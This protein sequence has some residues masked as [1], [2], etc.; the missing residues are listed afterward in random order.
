MSAPEHPKPDLSST[1]EAAAVAIVDRLQ[2][3][4]Y[5]AYFAGGCVRDRLLGIEPVDY[6]IA[7]DAPPDNVIEL[8]PRATAVGKSFGVVVV[9]WHE[10]TLEIATFRQDHAYEDGRRPTH[11]SFVTPEEDATRRDFT[12]NAMFYDPLTDELHDYVEGQADIAT[13]TIRCV[14]DADQRF[15]EDHLRMLRA[16]RFAA[17]FGFTIQPDTAKA[18]RRHA[19]K[20]AAISAERIRDE[21]TRTLLESEQPGQA[22]ALLETLGLLKVVLPEVAVMREQDQPPQFHPEG[23]VLTHTVMML[24][25]MEFRDV[26][27]AFAVLLHDVGKP[28]TAS[29]DGTRLRFNCHA[30]QGA[31]IARDILRRLRFPTRTIDDVTHCVRNHMRFLNV[32]EMRR[33]TLRRLLGTPTFPTELE[34]H[35]VDCMASHGML[36]NYA[37]LLAALEQ[38]DQEPVLPDPWIDGHTVMALGVEKGPAVGKWMKVAY[39]AQLEGTLPNKE[40]LLAWLKGQIESDRPI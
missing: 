19:G 36:D 6:D 20:V 18:I 22:V 17:R 32:K 14:G 13:G 33:A 27:L 4:G 15:S 35:R 16:V 1:Q 2:Q 39:D 40:A 21:L 26:V 23:D 5:T 29:H 31:D 38:M 11:V 37:F 8:F 28:P 12:I 9:P 25:A 34:L 3:A 30:E 7:T 10:W 24:D